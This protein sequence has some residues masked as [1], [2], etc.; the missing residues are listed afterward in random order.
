MQWPNLIVKQDIE[1]ICREFRETLDD[2]AICGSVTEFVVAAWPECVAIEKT[3]VD[4][5]RLCDKCRA[6][7]SVEELGLHWRSDPEKHSG[8]R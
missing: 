1:R 3:R 8:L 2:C 5:F 4:V 6:D 7:L